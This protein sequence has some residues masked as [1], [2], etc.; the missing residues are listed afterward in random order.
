MKR[1]VELLCFPLLFILCLKAAFDLNFTPDHPAGE[2]VIWSDKAAYYIYLPALFL[3]DFDAGKFPDER[4]GKKLGYGFDVSH[5]EGKIKT[6]MT[7]GV[8]VMIA[9]FFAV[10]AWFN[11]IDGPDTGFDLPFRKAVVVSGVFYLVLG[12]FFLRRFLIRYITEAAS[13]LTILALLFATNLFFYGLKENLMSHV[14]SFFLFSLLLYVFP[15]SDPARLKL[16][17]GITT[18]LV[19]GLLILVRPTHFMALWILLFF[20]VRSLRDFRERLSGLTRP[21]FIL[22]FLL[23]V[24]ALFIPQLLYWKYWTGNYIHY[25]YG[26]QGFSNICAPP[27]HAAW[28]SPLNGLFVYTPLFVLILAGIVSMI[29]DNKAGGWFLLIF[30]AVLSLLFASWDQW[31][32]GGS[33]GWRPMVDYFPLFSLPFGYLA[34][35]VFTKGRILAGLVVTIIIL[36]FAFINIRMTYQHWWYNGSVWDWHALRKNMVHAGLMCPEDQLFQWSDDFE[37]MNM[38]RESLSARGESRSGSYA[39][40]LT[41]S[42]TG[43]AIG[44]YNMAQVP[45]KR[46]VKCIHLTFHVM[47]GTT[48]ESD[49]L[50]IIELFSPDGIPLLR[51]VW[52]V[53]PEQLFQGNWSKIQ[54]WFWIPARIPFAPNY[55][56]ISIAN[57]SG[58][59]WLIDDLEL[60]FR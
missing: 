22:P 55:L 25:S 21:K 27:L 7:Y 24:I 9:P 2:Q 54:H 28:F 56:K 49:A 36:V 14:Y 20:Q 19:T 35:K 18:G 59:N 58:T 44:S 46:P 15:F 52:P 34:E 1:W 39:Q 50:L 60:V 4:I 32:Y 43:Q 6:R 37:N 8:A 11:E 16:K 17:S 45:L 47:T 48:P 33:F 57:S 10:A 13:W 29:R 51:Q 38:A 40:P 30:F 31:Y 12:L 26:E 5:K 53:T 23:V 42:L 3:Y 41:A